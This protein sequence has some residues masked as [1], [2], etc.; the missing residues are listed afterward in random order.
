MLKGVFLTGS[1]LSLV[2]SGYISNSGRYFAHCVDIIQTSTRESL[3]CKNVLTVV[4]IIK[5]MITIIIIIT[6]Q[7]FHICVIETQ[8]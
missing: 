3:I 6:N 2:G 4:E 5:G 1:H 8:V 7:K